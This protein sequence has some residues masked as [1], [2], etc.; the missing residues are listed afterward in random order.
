MTLRP[1]AQCYVLA[2]GGKLSPS[3]ADALDGFK[4]VSANE[5]C[6][7]LTGR[8]EGQGHLYDVLATIG[9]LKIDLISLRPIT[10]EVYLGI[11]TSR[12]ECESWMNVEAAG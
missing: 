8:V 3:A 2:V 4:V 11:E 6:T 12:Q 10:G 5:D 7:Y 9:T 1:V